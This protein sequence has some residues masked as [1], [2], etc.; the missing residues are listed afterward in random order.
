MGYKE[1]D[2]PAAKRMGQCARVE[3]KKMA[4]NPRLVLSAGKKKLMG[5][6]YTATLAAAVKKFT[7]SPVGRTR[8]KTQP[9]AGSAALCSSTL[10][11]VHASSA[12]TTRK[13]RSAVS[14]QFG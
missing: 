8:P 1:R 7:M 14:R 4:F 12:T 9:K 3:S 11:S 2:T 13:P 10:I 6:T 5:R